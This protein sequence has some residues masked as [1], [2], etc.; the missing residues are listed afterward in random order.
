MVT[1][2]KPLCNCALELYEQ[3][4]QDPMEYWATRSRAECTGTLLPK[5]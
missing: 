2:Q 5:C 1:T 4:A 3:A